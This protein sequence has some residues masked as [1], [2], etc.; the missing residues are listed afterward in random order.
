MRIRVEVFPIESTRWIAVIEAPRGPFSTET[1]RP[2][3]IEAEVKASVRGVLG[4]GPFEIELLD[5]L[6]QRW[7]V[8]SADAQSRRLGFNAG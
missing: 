7:T 5:D 8:A 4:K 3:D 1:L 6:G 2:E